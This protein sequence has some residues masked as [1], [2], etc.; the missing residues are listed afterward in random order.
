MATL[1]LSVLLYQCNFEDLETDKLRGIEVSPNLALRVGEKVIT[2][3]ELID[4]V[5]TDEIDIVTDDEQ[6]IHFM[7][8]EEID[9]G[10]VNDIITTMTVTNSE[11]LSLPAD[12]PALPFEHAVPFEEVFEFEFNTGDGERVDSVFFKS[13]TLEYVM[14]SE[15]PA[16]VDY[17]WE[18]VNT[19]IIESNV[20][21]SR[22]QSLE[23]IGVQISDSY[24]R[25]LLGL[26]SI[27]TRED[28]L[29]KFRVNLNGDLIVPANQS[30]SRNDKFQFDLTYQNPEFS[31]IFG[32]FNQQEIELDPTEFEL[33]GF[34]E[35]SGDGLYFSDPSITLT[36][37]NSF[38]IEVLLNLDGIRGELTDGS[39]ILL[40]TS[41]TDEDRLI[42]APQ[43]VGDS[44]ATTIVI[45]NTTSN[46]GELLSAFPESVTF[47]VSA[48]MNP[49][50][51]SLSSNFLT[52]TS[53][54]SIEAVV[55]I[56]LHLR[57]DEFTLDFDIDT[58]GLNEL[59]GAKSISIQ[60]IATNGIPFEGLISM[61]FLDDQG[62]ILVQPEGQFVIESPSVEANGRVVESQISI[63]TLELSEMEIEAL[64]SSS[65]VN[66]IV[67]VTTWR[68]NSDD[69]VKVFSDYELEL[70]LSVLGEVEI[71]L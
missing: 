17:D 58:E 57:L 33:G 62:E 35:I 68:E 66:T 16:S 19:K 36:V 20:N 65:K 64:L 12:I 55:D 49:D 18:I 25:P 43:F 70:A 48:E 38:G 27:I 71:E 14:T 28:D 30:I 31:S 67:K 26:K 53:F 34:D 39:E 54:V 51:S 63:S 23:Y 4:E 42:K 8:S 50:I 2:I 40:E 15:F 44:E 24:S 32:Y 10:D 41:M 61:V 45:N 69:G 29:N 22:S 59:Q 11:E 56:P 21:L 37:L 60:M 1:C 7:I 3:A 52:D 46:L 13:G 6:L 47:D 5:E 9:F